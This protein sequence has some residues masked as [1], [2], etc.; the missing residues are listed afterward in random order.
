MMGSPVE[1][2]MAMSSPGPNWLITE[3]KIERVSSTIE[4]GIGHI[5][6]SVYPSCQKNSPGQ[7]VESDLKEFLDVNENGRADSNT[8]DDIPIRN[9]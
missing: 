7:I 2:E 9:S 6:G 3:N 1:T 4:D 5:S 8:Y